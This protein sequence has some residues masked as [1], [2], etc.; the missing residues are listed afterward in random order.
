MRISVVIP[1]L[2]EAATIV[3][4]L[5]SLAAQRPDELVVADASSPDGTADLAR[6]AG[7]RVVQSPRGRG[8]QMNR[9]AGVTTGE[10]LLFLH[11]DCRLAPGALDVLRQFVACHP[12]V[13]GGCFRMKV[14]SPRPIYHLI[15][16][17]ADLRAGVFGI[18]YGD[19]GIFATREAFTRLGGFPELPLLEDVHFSL[20]LKR[21]GRIALIPS[22]I[23]VSSRRWEA[24]GPIRQT[25]RNWILTASAALGVSPRTLA[26]FY[27]VIR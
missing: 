1:T 16:A 27:P 24:C 25:L 3:G 22:R 5:R 6:R 13:P 11:A 21:L 4:S 14:D 12:A 10:V 8:V 23:H 20:R 19:Q 18:P 17:A 26:P 9:G 2:N 7:V 15:D